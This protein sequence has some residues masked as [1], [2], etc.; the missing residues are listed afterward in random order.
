MNY[1][2]DTSGVFELAA[3]HPDHNVIQAVDSV[4]P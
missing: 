3:Q 1:I 2:P 4:G